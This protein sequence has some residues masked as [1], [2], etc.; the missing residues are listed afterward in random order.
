LKNNNRILGVIDDRR[1]DGLISRKTRDIDIA[2]KA[3]EYGGDAVIFVNTDSHPSSVDKYGNINYKVL[4]KLIVV[5]Y[6]E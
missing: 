5:K 4:N 6:L 1:G 3:K 2:A